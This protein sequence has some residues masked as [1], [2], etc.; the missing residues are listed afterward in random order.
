MLKQ[1]EKQSNTCLFIAK[2]VLRIVFYSVSVCLFIALTSGCSNK[3]K[4]NTVIDTSD[5]VIERIPPAYAM[6]ECEKLK[7]LTDKSFGASIL[8]IQEIATL[9]NQCETKR[10]SLEDFI[11]KK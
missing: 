6:V 4:E 2:N 10:K 9:Y 1:Q 5:V 7:P 3:N 11:N 8:K